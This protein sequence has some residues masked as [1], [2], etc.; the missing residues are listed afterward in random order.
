LLT[1]V[2]AGPND[3]H[4]A[5]VFSSQNF[6]VLLQSWEAANPVDSN[7]KRPS[8]GTFVC[9]PKTEA[10]FVSA[11]RAEGA[12]EP[13]DF[14]QLLRTL[15]C[16][17]ELDAS[18]R[19]EAIVPRLRLPRRKMRQ[20]SSSDSAW[21]TPSYLFLGVSES[22]RKARASTSGGCGGEEFAFQLI[23]KQWKVTGITETGC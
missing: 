10:D 20:A 5:D 17:Q 1:L 13:R 3:G 2:V 23:G 4:G 9:S 14:I 18:A 21:E 22:G 6:E 8:I 11:A 19:F 16:Y 15:W 7:G 12:R